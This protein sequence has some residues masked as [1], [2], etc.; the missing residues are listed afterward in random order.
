MIDFQEVDNPLFHLFA[1][2]HF[3]PSGGPEIG[4]RTE[5]TAL[6]VHMGAKLDVVEYCHT[7]KQG[8]V[9]EGS[10][11]AKCSPPGR[12]DTARQRLALVAN[13]A[14]LWFVE[15]GDAV[16]KRGLAGT[17][18]ADNSRYG[19]LRYMETDVL[20]RLDAAK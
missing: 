9:L 8:Y 19:V 12:P 1:D 3:L 16:K 13:G 14:L 11:K 17:V 4:Q 10:G 18:R 20:Q 6:H 7:P 2:S 5:Q 15:T